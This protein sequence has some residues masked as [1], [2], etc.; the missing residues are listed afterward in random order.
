MLCRLQKNLKG[1][2]AML[3]PGIDLKGGSVAH[4]RYHMVVAELEKGYKAYLEPHLAPRFHGLVTTID[5][6]LLHYRP[7]QI[8]MIT[9]LALILTMTILEFIKE[10]TLGIQ[11][12]G[13]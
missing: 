3:E 11:E 9:A 2:A 5:R 6:Q 7:W 10:R 13:K 1:T 12:Q 8:V 4:R